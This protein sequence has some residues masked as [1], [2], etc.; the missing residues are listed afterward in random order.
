[1]LA[2]ERQVTLNAS[3]KVGAGKNLRRKGGYIQTSNPRGQNNTDTSAVI[4][5]SIWAPRKRVDSG[6]SDRTSHRT[7]GRAVRDAG[8]TPEDVAL[9]GNTV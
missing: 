3:H 1:M 6:G 2:T 5:N 7:S 8:I 4:G 9:R